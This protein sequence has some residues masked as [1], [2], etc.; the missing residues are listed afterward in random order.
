MG[1]EYRL[2][3][4][5]TS[6]PS[7]GTQHLLVLVAVALFL[8]LWVMA[9]ST[10]SQHVSQPGS[11]IHAGWQMGPVALHT[12]RHQSYGTH[13]LGN[14]GYGQALTIQTALNG[15][16]EVEMKAARSSIVMDDG[17]MRGWKT[18]VQ[19]GT[20]MVNWVWEAAG[21]RRDAH[22]RFATISKGF[23]P[24]I[25]IGVSHID[26]VM[27]QD[28]EDAFGREYHLWSDG[29]LR[30]IDEAGDHGGNAN[31]LR[32]DYTYES[33]VVQAE[34]ARGPGR[35]LAIPA[36]I[37]IRLDVSPRVRARMGI[38]GWLGLTDA[39][40]D[41]V[42]GRALS[43]DALASGFFGLGIRLGRL[44]KRPAAA[45][46]IPGVSAEDAALLASMDTDRDGIS[47]LHDRC[48]GTDSGVEVDASGCP[49]D[50]DGDGYA[51]YKDA[52]INSPHIDVDGRGVAL[53]LGEGQDNH[54]STDKSGWDVVT[55][56]VTSDDRT[57]YTLNIPTPAEG[58][59]LAEQHTLL[60]FEH[61][62]ESENG[63]K[64]KVSADPR[65][66]GRAAHAV[67]A[68]GL[69]A[70]LI[71]P[72]IE[73][74]SDAV[75]GEATE[76]AVEMG[77]FRVQMGAYRTPDPAALNA[78]FEGLE[79]LRF[80]GEDGL[81]RIVSP[82][83]EDRSEALAYQ[84][85]LTARGFTGAFVTEH[86]PDGTST[87]PSSGQ[88]QPEDDAPLAPQFDPAKIEFRIQLGALKTEMGV[89]AMDGLLH[90]GDIEHRSTTG[91]HRYLHGR[92]SSA[93]EARQE[94]PMLL[95]AGFED[96]FVVGDVAGRIIPVAEAEILLNQD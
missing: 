71:A 83:F 3:L 6:L 26:H 48:P 85:Q 34:G 75:G 51:D 37:G 44:K 40:D 38:G 64:V 54:S 65:E 86:A 73:S 23:Q 94:L 55:G 69:D 81:L 80:K 87:A 25:G 93:A 10:G 88:A 50:T 8:P 2:M 45:P 14:T 36:Q 30:D 29:T 19:S 41:Q 47:N 95:E 35:S 33:D 42:S 63:M 27:K 49:V 4:I 59:T 57:Q 32:R 28:L 22:T 1:R 56:R 52:E 31:I 74:P 17:A 5:S 13:N 70:E 43:G 90:L 61:L 91:W 78:L 72:E 58:W 21:S 92:F 77:H 46:V 89:D 9:Q 66:A 76:D 67:R 79:V 11:G 60:A 16:W 24:F 7:R 20:V 84:V 18:E 53:T 15:P 62:S 82:T 68:A 39:L 96:A 12:E